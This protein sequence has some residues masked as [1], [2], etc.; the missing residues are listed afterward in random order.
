VPDA[1]TNDTHDDIFTTL[2]PGGSFGAR[3]IMREDGPTGRFGPFAAHWLED[4]ILL[5]MS[6][7]KTLERSWKGLKP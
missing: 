1:L 4:F 5:T 7:E 3:R 2:R 6:L